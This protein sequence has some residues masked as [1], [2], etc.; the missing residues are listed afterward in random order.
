MPDTP[1][2]MTEKDDSSVLPGAVKTL[3][4]VRSVI[5]VIDLASRDDALIVVEPPAPTSIYQVADELFPRGRS[6]EI[7]IPNLLADLRLK[8]DE[9]G[10]RGERLAEFP[11]DEHV[12][13]L[14]NRRNQR[15]AEA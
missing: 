11:D 12:F 15:S 9:D 8:R 7:G 10:M 3:P 2:R 5:F 14:R 4:L 1:V 6:E 13:R